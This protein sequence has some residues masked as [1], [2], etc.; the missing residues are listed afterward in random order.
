VPQRDLDR[1][2]AGDIGGL[3]SV[4]RI[5]GA[6]VLRL[7]RALLGNDA[8]AQDAAQEVFLRAFAKLAT[9]DGNSRLSTWLYRLAM[10]HC[11]NERKARARRA[12]RLDCERAGEPV[13]DSRS[14]IER[15]AAVEAR[16]RV[17]G[18]L[19]ALSP[20]HRAVL[21]LRELEGLTYAAIAEVLEIP[22]GTVMSRLARA[23]ERL[24]EHA[25]APETNGAPPPSTNGALEHKT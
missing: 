23:R 10:N 1:C 12:R 16:E 19:A 3:E 7:C 11:L 15:A 24:T 6:R 8:D 14:P 5:H 9:F 21:V 25:H 18:L 20:D 13:D 17:D 4:L 2:R 22:I